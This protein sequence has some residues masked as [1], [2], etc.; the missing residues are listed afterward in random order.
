M[1][2]YVIFIFM[3]MAM[4]IGINTMAKKATDMMQS[5]KAN[6]A[7]VETVRKM[8]QTEQKLPVFRAKTPSGD[9]LY[10]E[11]AMTDKEREKGLMFRKNLD[12]DKGMMFFFDDDGEKGFWMKNTLIPLDIIFLD[13]N[14][15]VIKVFSNVPSSYIGAPEKE[16]PLVAWYGRNVLELAAGTAEGYGLRFGSRLEVIDN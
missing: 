8:E 13:E 2:R 15:A 6:P 1:A 4:F 11:K 9:I 16:I 5:K 10:L 7:K 14:F 12:R 3:A